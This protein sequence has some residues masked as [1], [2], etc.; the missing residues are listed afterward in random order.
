M[1]KASICSSSCFDLV[2]IALS[3]FKTVLTRLAS[4]VIDSTS[5]AC[6]INIS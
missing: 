3:V 4:L 6:R 1:S 5:E 2:S